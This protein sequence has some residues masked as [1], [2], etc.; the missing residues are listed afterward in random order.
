MEKRAVANKEISANLL[1][2]RKKAG[3][4][5]GSVRRLLTARA[6]CRAVANKEISANL[7]KTKKKAGSQQRSKR[8]IETARV[9]RQAVANIENTFNRLKARIEG[10][11][12]TKVNTVNRDCPGAEAGSSYP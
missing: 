1:K 2:A 12:S 4:H 6:I 10:R 9:V 3:S 11:Q 5:L 8:C 7:L